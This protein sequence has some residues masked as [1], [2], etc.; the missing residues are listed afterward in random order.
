MKLQRTRVSAYGLV[1]D[2]DRILLCRV[3]KALPRWQGQWTLPGG[4]I[5]FGEA[6]QDAMVREE[7][8]RAHV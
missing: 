5:N 1:T 6:P 3:S 4:G 2:P 7:I 8:G